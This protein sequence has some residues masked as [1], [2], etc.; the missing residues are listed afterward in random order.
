MR[1]RGRLR[2]PWTSRRPLPPGEPVAPVEEDGVR[3]AA[4]EAEDTGE[5]DTL[6]DAPPLALASGEAD[7]D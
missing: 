6:L 3:D 4:V 7:E 5:A 2:C 1:W